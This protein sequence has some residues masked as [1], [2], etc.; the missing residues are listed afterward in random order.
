M[1]AVLGNLTFEQAQ[2]VLDKHLDKKGTISSL[3][4]HTKPRHPSLP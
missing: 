1:A 3:E 4:P 2:A